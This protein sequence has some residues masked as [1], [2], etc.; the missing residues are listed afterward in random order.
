MLP[1]TSLWLWSEYEL[2]LNASKVLWN[3]TLKIVIVKVQL[4][5][6]RKIS[7]AGWYGTLKFISVKVKV[8]QLS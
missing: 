1:C 8:F 4:S 7:Q 6:A 3:I 5:Q 2:W